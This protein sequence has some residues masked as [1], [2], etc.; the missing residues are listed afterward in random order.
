[1]GRPSH[2]RAAPRARG[3]I[4]LSA[5]K[6]QRG[7][8]RTALV[9]GAS[10]G[11]GLE[12]ARLL[13]RDGY[14]LVLIARSE[15]RLAQI[16]RELTTKH[17]I[18]VRTRPKDLSRPEAPQQIFDELQRAAIEVE[19]LVNNAGFGLYGAFNETDLN[20]E[21]QMMQVNMVALTHLTKLLLPAM[22]ERRRGKILNVAS[23]AALQPGPLMAVYYATKAYVL[24]FSQALGNELEGS[25][26]SVTALCP[27][28]TT[29]GF[30]TRANMEGSRLVQGG[31]MDARTVAAIGYRALM[32]KQSVVIPGAKNKGFALLAKLL[33]GS[34]TVKIVRRAQERADGA[35]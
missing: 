16:A 5:S 18:A 32:R 25:G 22:L 20:D 4:R 7:G 2:R 12:L 24:S 19:V 29:S 6:A 8:H 23:T 33:P 21:L 27:G 26:V 34:M 14:D 11:I 13:A 28:P 1:M 10:G 17:N 30:Q 15:D 31:L 35:P 3:D 9:T